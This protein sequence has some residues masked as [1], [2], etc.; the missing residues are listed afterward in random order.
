MEI[1]ATPEQVEAVLMDSPR[2]QS[3]YRWSLTSQNA[4]IAPSTLRAGDKLL[5]HLDN[6]DFSPSMTLNIPHGVRMTEASTGLLYFLMNQ[7]WS[8]R[9][10]SIKNWEAF[11]R[12]L[13]SEVERR[14]N[15]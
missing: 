8:M 2:V 10:K 12:G 6:L 4:S 3:W 13:K 11:F 15:S 14:G 5:V 9:D 1:K 7:G